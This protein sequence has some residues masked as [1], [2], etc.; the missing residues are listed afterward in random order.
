VS[1]HTDAFIARLMQML[2]SRAA[3][4]SA[5]AATGNSNRSA[6]VYGPDGSLRL[7]LP[8]TVEML[9]AIRDEMPTGD[10]SW[11]TDPSLMPVRP[12]SP[13]GLAG[14]DGS[15]SSRRWTPEQRATIAYLRQELLKLPG[16][17]AEWREREGLPSQ[18]STDEEPWLE[19]S[20]AVAP[21][22]PASASTPSALSA[23]VVDALPSALLSPPTA[24]DGQ[25]SKQSMALE[26]ETG[27][28]C[29]LG[30]AAPETV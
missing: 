30:P 9:A 18:D 15:S 2:E 19:A 8:L 5:P 20:R 4:E 11:R 3:P 26:E 21:Q 28:E 13:G 17:L 24:A 1:E 22:A 6:S 14:D 25:A 29:S 12:P 7:A 27:S 23:P 10:P 16:D